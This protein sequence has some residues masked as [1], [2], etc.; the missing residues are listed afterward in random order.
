LGF[1]RGNN[2][3]AA[4][5]DGDLLVFLNND[6]RPS[7]DWLGT[8]VQALASAPPDVA[9]VGG[10]T[11]D[12]EGSHL[13]FASGMMTFDGHAFQK[14]AGRPLGDVKIPSAGSELFF[15]NGANM[16]IWRTD[17]M[18]HGAFDEDFFAYYDDVDLGWRL[19][20]GGKRILFDP[21]AVVAHRGSATSGLLGLFNRGFLYERNAFFN[22][23]K[24]Y[25]Q[26]MWPRFMP[27]ILLT[28]LSRTQRL[29]EFGNPGGSTLAWD[30]YAG[31]IANSGM[32]ARNRVFSWLKRG[33]NRVRNQ[34][35]RRGLLE[36][37][38]IRHFPMRLAR[39]MPARGGRVLLNDPRT[40]AQFRA[41]HSIFDRMADYEAKRHRVQNRRR[42]SDE[43]I[44]KRFPPVVVPT[45]PGDA[46]L[47]NSPH[48]RLW[49]PSDVPLEQSTLSD[50]MAIDG[51]G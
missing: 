48:F 45:Y 20:A 27:M 7:T 43:D 40:V 28:L 23:Y 50:I 33:V 35:A 18:K 31:H 9:A 12:W 10:M 37:P 25:S 36:H 22:A 14:D 24:N 51:M 15:A 47:F 44:L 30:P 46:Q 6:T 11:T 38:R 21:Q 34:M 3:L 49:L 32:S 26:T 5:T 16:A 39:F 42:R 4:E 13:D 1:A 41:I 29:L 8:L 19:W 2:R 17:F